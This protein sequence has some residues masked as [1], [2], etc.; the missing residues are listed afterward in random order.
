MNAIMNALT[1]IWQSKIMTLGVVCEILAVIAAALS[2]PIIQTP[3]WLP[4]AALL[5]A[6]IGAAIV[7]GKVAWDYHGRGLNATQRND[8]QDILAGA[9]LSERQKEDVQSILASTSLNATQMEKVAEAI[10]SSGLTE[11]QKS[12]LAAALMATNAVTIVFAQ[13]AV[14]DAINYLRE[15]GHGYVVVIHATGFSQWDVQC[16]APPWAE[17][18]CSRQH[19]QGQ[20][21]GFNFFHIAQSLIQSYVTTTYLWTQPGSPQWHY[22]NNYDPNSFTNQLVFNLYDCVPEWRVPAT[23]DYVLTPTAP[24]HSAWV[25]KS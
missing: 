3:G 14:A 12:E 18:G 22:T 1:M 11:R 15:S 13:K 8:V 4:Y 10:Q 21:G 7:A 23:G 2:A 19:V 6:T 17:I 9:S 25:Q 16:V 5:M 20:D 24:N